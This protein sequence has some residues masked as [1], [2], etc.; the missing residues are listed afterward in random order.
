MVTA[1]P[2]EILCE[3]TSGPPGVVTVV[4]DQPGRPVVVLDRDLIARLAVTLDAVPRDATGLILASASTRSFVAGADLTS[5]RAEDEGGLSDSDLHAY[6]E[7]G[8]SV[9]AKLLSMPF[10]TA[11]AINGATLGGGLE[12][13]LHC[14]GLIGAP[15]PDRD[16]RPGKPYPVG[17]PE[18]G[19]RI[20]PGWGGTNLLPART[21]P[22]DAIRRT[23]TGTAWTYPEAVDAR[24]FDA[25][26]DDAASLRRTAAAWLASQSWTDRHDRPA[27]WVGTQGGAVMQALDQVRME[28]E[29]DDEPAQ[30]VFEAIDAGLARGWPD[31][32]DTERARLVEL[33]SRP[34]GR[35]AIA[36]F[37]DRPKKTKNP[38]EPQKQPQTPKHP[39]STG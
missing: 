28:F 8:A 24:L 5:I 10:P 4:L 27:R 22:A 38:T 30:A 19:L 35:A 36:G 29:P 7:H 2:F 12:L 33:R 39:T 20:C 23:A 13:A 31:A 11:A 6:L 3:H 25:V 17:L 1:E 15:P 21:A 16:G 34:T 37:L 26:A 32:L 18:A 14:D 9:F